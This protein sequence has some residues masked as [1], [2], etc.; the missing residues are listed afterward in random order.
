M[1]K[2]KVNKNIEV[3]S[4]AEHVRLRPQ[5]YIGAVDPIEEKIPIVENG[6]LVRKLKTY[7]MGMY[8][9]FEEALDNAIDEAKRCISQEVPFKFIKVEV[10]AKAR[11]VKVIDD[12]QGFLNGDQ[13]NKK[14]NK[15]NIETAMTHLRAGS[16]FKNEETEVALIGT[17]GVG[18]SCVNILSDFF[19]ISTCLGKN[20][21]Y[22]QCWINFEEQIKE[23]E[24]GKCKGTYVEFIPSREIFEGQEWDLEIIKTKMIFT[25]F[26]LSQDEKLKDIQVQLFWTYT[27]HETPKEVNLNENFIPEHNIHWSTSNTKI[28]LWKKETEDMTSISFVNG[29]PCTGIHQ[30]IVLDYANDEIFNNAQAG[31]FYETCVITSLSPKYVKFDTQNKVRLVTAKI[32]LLRVLKYQAS[33]KEL[34]EFSSNPIYLEILES[35]L[36]LLRKEELKDFK[37]AKK[38]AK[39][40][41]SDKFYSSKTKEN[42]FICEGQSALSP[43]LQKR[44][45]MKDSAYALRGKI[46]NV[47]SVSDLTSNTEIV[48][49]INI[50]NLELEDKG[51]KCSY[52]RV[53]IATDWDPDGIGH[54]ASLLINFFALWFP[55]LIEKDRLFILQ[56]PLVSEDVGK[57]RNYYYSLNDL[58]KVSGKIR[59]LKGL[60][61]LDIRDWEYVFK[62]MQLLKI[63]MDKEAMRHLKMA[64]GNDVQL[65]KR[66]LKKGN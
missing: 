45:P 38:S 11:S 56:T 46:K 15:S 36:N 24:N 60:G 42:L 27:D 59:Y 18:I 49:L 52:S 4:D 10:N 34:K 7:S 22:L 57:K 9:L 19:K 2:Q 54:I 41:I 43:L 44:D 8:R 66:W 6:V 53:I 23:I 1:A 40:T 55:K 20:K 65:R 30:K 14:T 35:I 47:K 21:N 29:T 17:N 33:K 32:D 48:D 51:E 3:L 25:K 61:S 31:K 58:S 37:K 50:L 39:I 13:L 64:F 62:N 12:G 5:M 28:W 63:K 16:N 26:I